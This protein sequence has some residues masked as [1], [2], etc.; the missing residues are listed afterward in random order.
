MRSAAV[1]IGWSEAL[2]ISY[3]NSAR[4]AEIMSVSAGASEESGRNIF[5]L[6][7]QIINNCVATGFS[8]EITQCHVGRVM[9]AAGRK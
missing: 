9:L 6:F 7:W 4:A 8:P 1:W 3:P 2:S 5:F